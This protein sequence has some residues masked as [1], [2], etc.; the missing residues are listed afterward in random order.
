MDDVNSVS[1]DGAH[2]TASADAIDTKALDSVQ[3]G[4]FGDFDKFL[5]AKPEEQTTLREELG[6]K[7]DALKTERQKVSEARVAAEKSKA[8]AAKNAK[9]PDYK[10][11]KLPENSLLTESHVSET[12]KLAEAGKWDVPTLEAVL[13]RD[14]KLL[15]GNRAKLEADFKA[16]NEESLKTLTNEWGDKFKENVEA[17]SRAV[18]FFEK[19]IPGIKAEIDRLGLSNSVTAN[20]FFKMIHDELDMASDKFEFGTKG[21]PVPDPLKQTTQEAAAQVFPKSMAQARNF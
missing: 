3:E 11:A 5:V 14:A 16:Y 18:G 4:F 2:P 8:E 10:T 17:V 19:Q 1:T 9:P 7:Y 13:A 12:M 6:K 20:K 21:A 15:D